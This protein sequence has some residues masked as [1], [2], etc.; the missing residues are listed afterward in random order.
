MRN[1]NFEISA[2]IGEL[3]DILNVLDDRGEILASIKIDEAIHILRDQQKYELKNAP[4][5]SE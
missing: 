4:D 3:E 2:L 5:A 1:I